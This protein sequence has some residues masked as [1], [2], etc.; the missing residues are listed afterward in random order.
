MKR[1]IILDALLVTAVAVPA[2]A[3]DGD[4]IEEP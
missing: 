4:R 2:A 3:Q 1:S